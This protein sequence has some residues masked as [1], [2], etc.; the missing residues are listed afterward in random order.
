MKATCEICSAEFRRT[1]HLTRHLLRHAGA[2]P[3]FCDR[4]G[5]NFSRRDTLRRHILAHG[6]GT[7][8]RAH[9]SRGKAGRAYQGCAK[10]KQRCDGD[11]PCHRC[12]AKGVSCVY[13][14]PKLAPSTLPPPHASVDVE[15]DPT[16]SSSLTNPEPS[17]ASCASSPIDSGDPSGPPMVPLNYLDLM[18][19]L[20]AL[21]GYHDWDFTGRYDAGFPVGTQGCSQSKLAPT[22]L[23][24]TLADL[25]ACEPSSSGD[26]S[27]SVSPVS[28]APV[29]NFVGVGRRPNSRNNTYA[30]PTPTL[31]EP[32]GTDDE[33]WRVDD[34]GH[35]PHLSQGSYDAIAD[36]LASVNQDNGFYQSFTTKALP[37]LDLV[38][39]FIQ[40]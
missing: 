2:R 10:A 3:F 15:V 20:P 12:V 38:N 35:V 33:D 14:P 16:T 18:E 34:Y 23:S 39:S 7:P 4:C 31:D 6:K 26:P 29:P 13:P 9:S 40:V 1:E 25:L 19:P 17:S 22:P 37:S 32:L 5:S 8:L 24:S 11:S 28:E 27:R 21:D 30:P 36:C